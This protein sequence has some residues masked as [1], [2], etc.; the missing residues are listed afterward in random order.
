MK[1]VLIGGFVAIM[2]AVLA[3]VVLSL[4]GVSTSDVFSTPNVRLD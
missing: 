4:Y 3:A 2:I 1:S